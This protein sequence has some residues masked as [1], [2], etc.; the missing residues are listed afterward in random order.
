MATDSLALSRSEKASGWKLFLKTVGA[1]AYPRVIGQQRE[2][3]W[4]FF[5]IFMPMMA[6]AAYVYV[7]R[8][9]DAPEEYVGFVVIGGAMTAFWMNVLWNMSSQLYWEKEQGNLALYIMSPS[10]MMAI[11]LG[12]ALGGLF[13]SALRAF[14]V[15]T[16]GTLLFRV[17]YSISSFTQLSLVFMLAMTALYGMGMMSASLF[18]LL[19][20]EAW[21]ITNLAQE[22][23]YLVSG[24]YFP[25]KSFNF[26]VAAAASFIPLTLGL[27]AMRQLIFP[28]GETLGFLNVKV[29]IVILV[30][31]CVVFLAGAKLLLDHMEKLAIR[32][33]RITESRR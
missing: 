13:A 15:I 32:E 24:F 19:S 10:S 9:I 25:I 30:V 23:V 1:R 31:L 18:L 12:M 2:K 26:W 22:P 28:S 3:S 17:Q 16:L 4:I 29:E 8:A 27:D 21:H 20:R 11:L 6:V 33:G 14:A 5:E 7:Y